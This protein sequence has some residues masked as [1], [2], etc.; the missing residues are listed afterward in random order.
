VQEGLLFPIFDF[1]YKSE[2]LHP[3]LE[4]DIRQAVDAE[5]QADSKFQSVSPENYEREQLSSRQ[6][7]GAILHRMAHNSSNALSSYLR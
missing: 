7:I 6:T 2:I 3:N 5:S 1:R 4:A